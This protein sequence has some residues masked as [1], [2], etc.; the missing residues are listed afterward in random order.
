[1]QQGT[2]QFRNSLSIALQLLLLGLQL[3]ALPAPRPRALPQAV[4]AV[5]SGSARYVGATSRHFFS[6][7]LNTN[8]LLWG[9]FSLQATKEGGAVTLPTFHHGKSVA[10][11]AGTTG[12]TKPLNLCLVETLFIH[13]LSVT[14]GQEG[15]HMEEGATHSQ[16][17]RVLSTIGA[18]AVFQP[19]WLSCARLSCC[20]PGL[21]FAV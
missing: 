2:F 5:S 17:L 18:L 8:Q 21:C 13:P 6:H 10:K 19:T 3:R 7:Q 9:T 4:R 16:L 14:V 12:Q 15:A 20:Y 11:R 1:M